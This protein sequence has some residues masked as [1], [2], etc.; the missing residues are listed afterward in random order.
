MFKTCDGV[1]PNR[2]AVLHRYAHGV[3]HGVVEQSK[4]PLALD[5]CVRTADDWFAVVTEEL[6]V[7]ELYD[8][9]VR[10]D[11]G[12]VVVFSGTIRDHSV[13][14]SEVR[15]GVQFLEYE[16]YAS[17]AVVRMQTIAHTARRT[18]PNLG[19]IAIVH[20][21]GRVGLGE[22]SVLVVVSAPHRPE[23]FDAARYAIDAVKSSVPIWKHET[24]NGGSDWG[25]GATQV[26]NVSPAADHDEAESA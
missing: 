3:E 1:L 11:C 14:G 24:W 22:S 18:W 4:V 26:S 7:G 12:A 19:R 20:R 2:P 6:S 15:S 8:W 17:E 25:L 5:D 9:A 23:A 21:I 16:A 13:E 10:A